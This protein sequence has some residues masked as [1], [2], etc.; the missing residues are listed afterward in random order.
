MVIEPTLARR[1][2]TGEAEL[3]EF[4]GLTPTD[5][6][7]LALPALELMRQGRRREASQVFE[8]LIALDEKAPYGHAALGFLA[9]ES[10]DYSLA[11]QHLSKAYLLAPED[12][13]IALNFAET[14]LRLDRPADAIPLLERLPSS[15]RIQA[16]LASAKG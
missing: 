13:A 6:A 14:L 1:L 9:L 2:L 10:E 7:A 15:P 5:L 3:R 16:L 4:F 12:P 8:C 11:V